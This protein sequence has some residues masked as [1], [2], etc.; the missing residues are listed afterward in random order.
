MRA[1]I[2]FLSAVLLLVASPASAA[3]LHVGTGMTYTSIAA[4]A[5]A[6]HDGDTI[7]IEAGTYHEEVVFTANGLTIQSVGGE[8][9][10]DMTGMT[11]MNQGGK[12]IFILD[13]ADTTVDGITF[14]GATDGDG[15]GAG[16][17]W[18][19]GGMLTVRNC[20]FRDDEDGI[21]GGNHPDNVALIENNEFLGSGRGEFGYTHNIY[22][23]EI[24]TLTFR[25]NYSH[26]LAT[27]T[28]DIGHLFKSRA[29]H[30]YVLYN[31]LTAEDSPASY[32]LQLPEGGIAYVI[33]NLIEQGTMDP[34][35]TI[36]SIGGD[37][38]QWPDHHVFLIN[39]TIVNQDTAG[40]FVNATAPIDLDIVN[41]LFVGT[42]TLVSGGNV[43]RMTNNLTTDTSVFV[44]AAT[45]DYHLVAGSMPIDMGVD[46]GSD[47]A[48]SLAPILQY[49]H[50]RATEAR[51][52][53]GTI[54]V[55]AYEFGVVPMVDAG[56][57]TDAGSAPDSGVRV[58]AGGSGGDAG[59]SHADGGTSAPSN[60]GCGCGV[61]GARAPTAA[62]PWLVVAA[63]VALRRRR[64]D[65]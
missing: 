52:S 29:H 60:G 17:R 2:L 34:N 1:R 36:I 23:S 20:T 5:A 10:I 15:N 64:R 33:G 3:T 35:H 46:P 58:D 16:I 39:N 45:F 63:A 51:A 21:L 53:V 7:A 14:V 62:I 19:G 54:D 49:V 38:M 42:G 65:P 50:P 28:P 41:N 6:A 25:G 9:V 8:V 13:G 24:D 57:G 61:V 40:T 56:A 31:R 37:G 55:G 48:M 22:I 32:E 26:S 44:D 11:L 43:M 27:G 4:A 30:N 18:Q 59:T 12:G 47:G